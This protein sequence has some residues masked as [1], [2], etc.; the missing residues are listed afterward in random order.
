[1]RASLEIRRN[2][3]TM[4][5]RYLTKMASKLEKAKKRLH[6]QG[7]IELVELETEERRDGVTHWGLR[8]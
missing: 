5:S 4:W 3:Q 2:P 1:M 6:Q 8:G 7:N